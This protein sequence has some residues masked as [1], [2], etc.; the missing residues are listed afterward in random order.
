MTTWLAGP[1]ERATPSSINF[2]IIIVDTFASISFYWD[3]VSLS[4]A[5]TWEVGFT[6]T[7]LT[8]SYFWHQW[9]ITGKFL[10]VVRKF[11]LFVC[12]CELQKDAFLDLWPSDKQAPLFFRREKNTIQYLLYIVMNFKNWHFGKLSSTV[13][14]TWLLFFCIT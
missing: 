2:T 11:S 8:A 5:C 12:M 10:S 14:V 6:S 9:L 4:E 13:I 1:G 3:H 7:P